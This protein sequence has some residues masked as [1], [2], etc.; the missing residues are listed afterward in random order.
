MKKKILIRK[1]IVFILLVILI[2]F[3]AFATQLDKVV[4]SN[5]NCIFV[6]IF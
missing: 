3:V 6:F 5:F 4:G 2:L 1:I